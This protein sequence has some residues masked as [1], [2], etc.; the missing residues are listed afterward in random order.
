M[1][2]EKI[3]PNCGIH[4]VGRGN[5][6]NDEC[7]YEYRK[8]R[9]VIWRRCKYCGIFFATE[10]GHIRQGRGKH[11]SITCAALSW[12]EDTPNRAKKISKSLIGREITWGD[13]ISETTTGRKLP[14]IHKQ[15]IG[16]GVNRSFEDPE[17]RMRCSRPGEQNGMF[18]GYSSYGDY[19]EEF[20]EQRKEECREQY[21]G[22]CVVCGMTK[23][24]NGRK[25]DVHHIDYNKLNSELNNLYPLCMFCHA[26]TK[27]PN[28]GIKNTW[29]AW[30]KRMKWEEELGLR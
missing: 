18:N 23:K 14:E 5:C 20:N 7:G 19:S 30:F 2:P 16:I 12:I 10:I 29:Y 15:N 13:K 24:E 17:I 28:E 25:L 26:F 1:P 8:R 22:K 3:C 9:N 6:H 4:F 21:G 11:C 27:V